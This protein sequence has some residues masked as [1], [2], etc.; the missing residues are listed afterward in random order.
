MTISLKFKKLHPDAILPQY[1][2]PGAAGMDLCSVEDAELKMGEVRLVATGLAVEIP[3]GFELQ[4]RARSGLAAKAGVFL[5]N[6]VGTIDCDYR[7]EMK[8]ILST[9]QSAP[10]PIKKGDR[11]AQ[12]VLCR[13]VKADCLEVESLSSTERASGGFGSTGVQSSTGL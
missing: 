4:I 11:I 6:G 13:V 5:V 7:G 1:Q 2:T 9:C 3:E 8:V 10:V 12:A